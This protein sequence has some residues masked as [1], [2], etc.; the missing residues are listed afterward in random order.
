MTAE[1]SAAVNLDFSL[2]AAQGEII[3]D[4]HRFIVVVAG[5]RFGKSFVA[6][7]RA[8]LSALSNNNKRRLPVWIVAPTQPQAKQIYWR[9]LMNMLAPLIEHSNVNE[10]IITLKTGVQI[11]VKGSDR[12][13]SLRGVG[14]YDVIL[15]E[16]ATMKPEVWEDIIRPALSDVQGRALFIGT[17]EGRNHFY[18]LYTYAAQSGDE[19]WSAHQYVSTQ[20]I[21]LP[22][23]EVEAARRSLSST[24]FRKEYMASFDNSGAGR[25]KADW[26]KYWPDDRD[27][28]TEGD[29]LVAIDLAGFKAMDT[30]K[31]R[32]SRLDQ[33]VICVARVWEKHRPQG[34]VD[35]E[36]LVKN[37]HAGRWTIGDTVMN[38]CDVIERVRPAA[39]GVERGTAYNAVMPLVI[40][41][42]HRRG[43]SYAPPMPLS[44]ENQRKE[45]RILYTLEGR[46]EHGNIWFKRGQWNAAAEDQLLQF[47]SKLVHDDYPDALAYVEQVARG[48]VFYQYKEDH[49]YGDVNYADDDDD[50]SYWQPLDR[51]AGF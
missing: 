36:W 6:K 5:R 1:K 50:P 25:I 37:M 35:Q 49:V 47:P 18:D 39:W 41:E 38:I 29:D 23:G 48:R 17:P 20:N 32:E 14:L 19:E 9:D 51:I 26:I 30:S 11:G 34:G 42:L 31:T 13:D 44:H 2:H 3:N 15:D 33:T 7:V 46:F 22:K 43:I 27:E 16:Y 12:P 4:P 45:D 24:V 28:P 10:G 8:A 40:A 21:Y